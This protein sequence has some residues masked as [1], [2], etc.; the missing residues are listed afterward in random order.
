MSDNGILAIVPGEY[1]AECRQ[2]L[3]DPRTCTDTCR[4]VEGDAGPRFG[5]CRFH[6]ERYTSK[7]GK[8]LHYFWSCAK[9]EPVP[10]VESD[11]PF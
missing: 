7:K 5:R 9:V 10:P 8:M 2:L 4:I 11:A 6:F 1:V 3:P